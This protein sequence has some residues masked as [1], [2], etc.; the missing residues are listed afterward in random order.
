MV[1]LFL[2]EV[3]LTS[4]A[5]PDVIAVCG[6]DLGCLFDGFVTGDPVIASET[7]IIQQRNEQE[8]SIIGRNF[9]TLGSTALIIYINYL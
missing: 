9:V 1:P 7:L 4:L 3:N 5:S 8:A 2:D 6:G